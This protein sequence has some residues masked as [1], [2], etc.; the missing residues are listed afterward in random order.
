MS[1]LF[2]SDA[3]GAFTR[4][5]RI[6]AA[7][8][9]LTTIGVG[10]L[11][12]GLA[13]PA[14]ADYAPGPLDVIGVGSDVAQYGIDFGADGDALGDAGFNS[15]GDSFK[16]VYFNAVADA[17]GRA[18]YANGSTAKVPLALNPTVALRAGSYPL[19]RPQSSGAGVT[20]LDADTSKSDPYI[21]FVGS[22]SYPAAGTGATAVTNGWGGLHVTE[23]ATDTVG[24][25]TDTTTNA[26]TLSIAQLL[27]IY[28]GTDTTWTQ[29]GGTSSATIIPEIP[30]SGSS[31]Y[32]TFI[33]DLTTAN[34]GTAPTLSSVVQ[35]VEQNDPTAIT[36][37]SSP[38][39]AIVPFSQGRLN[40]WNGVSG[41]STLTGGNPTSLYFHNPATVYPGAAPLTSGITIETGSGAYTSPLTIY[42]VFRQSDETSTTPWQPGGT[43]NWAQTLFSDPGGPA[44]FFDT[45]EGQ[46][47]LAEAGLVP[48]YV[49]NTSPFTG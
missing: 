12:A 46:I 19:Q 10:A 42:A 27:A 22:A 32:K 20:A 26:P 4:R 47:L 33:A 15:A 38:A 25:A 13:L 9:A 7:G 17:N 1:N 39:N 5:R 14:Q 18:A 28:Q 48:H 8:L 44:P 21:D 11:S 24:I 45:T 16:L 6:S 30:P 36:S 2:T 23:L 49:D 34:G 31:V 37:S 29:V 41:N 35:T 3:A 43:L 40:L